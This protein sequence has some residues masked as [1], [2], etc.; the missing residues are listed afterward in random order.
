MRILYFSHAYTTHDRRFLAKLVEPGHEV[1]FLPLHDD[2]IAYEK[3][4]LPEGVRQVAWTRDTGAITP[5]TCLGR[6]PAFER[7]L[8]DVDPDLVQAGPIPTCAFMVTLSG[9]R[10]LIAASWGS[11]ILVQVDEDPTARWAAQYALDRSERFLV[12]SDVVRARIRGMTGATDDRFIQFPWGIDL[13]RFPA[14]T[15]RGG[16]RQEIIVLCTRS[17]APIYGVDTALQAFALAHR[18]EPRLRLVLAGDGPLASQISETIDRLCLTAVVR[19]PGRV[20][21]ED[22]GRLFAAADVYLSCALSDGTSISL[23][24]AMAHGL[25]VVATGAFGNP[26]WITPERGGW[27]VPPGD[28]PAFARA[29]LRAARL[30]DPERLEIARHNRSVV[31]GRADWHANSRRLLDAISTVP[32]RNPGRRES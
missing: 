4:D 18:E 27:L 25:P 22:L 26:E 21:E 8:A 5:Q 6:M 11:D 12:D 13:A 23:L 9:F 30:G 17:W 1:H 15:P 29:L 2:G 31:E 10:P 24:E 32:R 19:C 3:R 16:P 28:A 14:S 20:A 7:V